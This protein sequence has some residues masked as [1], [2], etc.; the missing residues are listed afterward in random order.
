MKK[1][2]LTGIIIILLFLSSGTLLVQ[3]ARY[4]D[5]NAYHRSKMFEYEMMANLYKVFPV[6]TPLD[7]FLGSMKLEP[8]AVKKKNDPRFSYVGIKPVLR[9]PGGQQRDY[10][11]FYVNFYQDRISSIEPAGPDEVKIK[12]DF[13]KLAIGKDFSFYQDL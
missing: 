9:I 12:V 2:L 6:G 10:S 8:N 5:K 13:S 1:N 4:K 3:Y 7:S 11:G